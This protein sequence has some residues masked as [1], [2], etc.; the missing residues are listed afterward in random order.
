MKS[1]RAGRWATRELEYE[2]KK[3]RLCF[4]DWAD[5]ETEFRKNFLPIDS[6][7]T[8]IN[9][10]ETSNYFQ[11]KR[12]VDD[13]LDQF[14]DLIE[15]SGYTNLKTVVVKF[16]R[17]LDRRISSALASMASGRP[18]DNKP[19]EWYHLA[20]QLDQNRAAEEAFQSSHKQTHIPGLIS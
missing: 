6:E 12:T 18:S 2:A 17:G 19:E 14:R 13:Y 20:V 4:I 16:R 5:F 15:E 3:G 11:G 8:A 10:L 1:G 7:A 9:T